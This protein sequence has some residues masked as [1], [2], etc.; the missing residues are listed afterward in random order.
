MSMKIARRLAGKIR[1]IGCDGTTR[2]EPPS[3]KK[4]LFEALEQRI[5][6]SADISSAAEVALAAGLNDLKTWTAGLDDL[7]DFTQ[8]LPI[9]HQ[10]IGSQLDIPGLIQDRLITPVQAYFDA[11]GTATTDG[12]VAALGALPDTVGVVTGDLIGDEYFFDL[13]L[14]A[15]RNL[16]VVPLDLQKWW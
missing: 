2:F 7:S 1:S 15:T 11:P 12:L 10:S 3:K 14:Q 13:T 9:T 6:L 8:L 16:P 5:L 4:L